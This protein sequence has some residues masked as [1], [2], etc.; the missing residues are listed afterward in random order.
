MRPLG[1]RAQ[2]MVRFGLVALFLSVLL[3][4]LTY[5][6]VRQ[7]LMEDRLARAVDQA[8]GDS[9]VVAATLASGLAN[10]S[11]VLVSLR[12]PTRSTPLVL[13]Q[14]EWFAASLQVRPDDIPEPLAALVLEGNAA[15]Q[16]V[17]IGDRV[18][19]IVGV[20]LPGGSGSYFEV[21]SLADVATTLTTL[22]QVLLAGGAVTTLAGGALGALLARR[23]LKPLRDVADAA[24]RI[25]DG[26]LASR[27]DGATDQDLAALSASFNR[28]AE[29]LQ[30]RIAREERFASDVAH[31]LRTPLTTV[32]TSL[33]VLDGRREELSEAGQE[34]LELLGR[35]VR[36]LERT[37]RD[38]V[39]IAK[40]DAGVVTVELE[41]TPVATVLTRSLNRLRRPDLPVEIDKD[42]ARSLVLIDEVR[43][44][45]VL[46]NLIE[47]GETHG[48]GVTRLTV[49][50]V[51]DRIRLA[52]E[53]DGPGIAMIDRERVFERFARGKAARSSRSYDGSG[54]GLAL[55]AENARLQGGS[56][57]VEES[58][59]GGARLV[60][61]LAAEP[62]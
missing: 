7:L 57:W 33:A 14:G 35:D 60:V 56:V 29:S 49:N 9:R 55:A 18:V 12:P 61:D 17:A 38:L 27:L 36:R 16:T 23:V 52:V 31:E 22:S 42:A 59:T 51:G 10:P 50:R 48:G 47:N 13:W 11:D 19:S 1:L 3:G 40:H 8:A 44:E 58:E 15:R 5:V 39:E 53:D 46:V 24:T 41:P 34:A 45:R 37:A 43:F 26:E 30:S 25:A 28:M 2:I 54:L 4:V 20:P 6:S 21:F 32:L 62:Q